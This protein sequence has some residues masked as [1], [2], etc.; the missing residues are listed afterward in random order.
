MIEQWNFVPHVV[1]ELIKLDDSGSPSKSLS[2]DKLLR[3]AHT[4]KNIYQSAYD[5][6]DN[7]PSRQ[8]RIKKKEGN[9]ETTDAVAEDELGFDSDETIEMTE[10]EIEEACK[11]LVDFS[12]SV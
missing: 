7:S 10:E 6:L 11:G 2:R 8:S 3:Q 4:F 1:E 9:K 12:P 5:D